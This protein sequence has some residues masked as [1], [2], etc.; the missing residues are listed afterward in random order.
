VH[1]FHLYTFWNEKTDE[2]EIV[3]EEGD[4]CKG[5][6]EESRYKLGMK[7]EGDIIIDNPKYISENINKM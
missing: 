3:Y 5:S 2:V 4:G 7:V 6:K 1:A